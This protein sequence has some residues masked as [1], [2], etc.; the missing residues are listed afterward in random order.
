MVVTVQVAQV[1]RVRTHMVVMVV[2]ELP[3]QSLVPQ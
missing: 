2:Q 1:P 3:V